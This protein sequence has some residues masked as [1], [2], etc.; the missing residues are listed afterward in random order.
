MS[1]VKDSAL[2]SIDGTVIVISMVVAGVVASRWQ[3][4]VI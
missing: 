2:V 1:I 3:V 4:S